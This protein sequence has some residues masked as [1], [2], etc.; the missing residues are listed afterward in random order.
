MPWLFYVRRGDGFLPFTSARNNA[1]NQLLSQIP[2]PRAGVFTVA[3]ELGEDTYFCIVFDQMMM[4][5]DD[6]APESVFAWWDGDRHRPFVWSHVCFDRMGFVK[7]PPPKKA[8]PPLPVKSPPPKIDR[9]PAPIAVKSCPPKKAPPPL[10]AP[11]PQRCPPSKDVA[12]AKWAAQVNV[13]MV[14]TAQTDGRIG[15]DG[16]PMAIPKKAPP[17]RFAYAPIQPDKE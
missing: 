14:P 7:S 11:I 5:S 6:T 15:A 10:R 3:S 12:A 2:L 8:P 13:Q 16:W 1:I 4:Y 17:T 9:S